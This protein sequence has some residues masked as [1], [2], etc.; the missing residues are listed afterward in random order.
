MSKHRLRIGAVVG[1]GLALALVVPTAAQ[2]AAPY[3]S[4][5]PPATFLNPSLAGYNTFWTASTVNFTT[6]GA[7]TSHNFAGTVNAPTATLERDDLL[8]SWIN[9]NATSGQQ[10]KAI[11]DSEYNNAANTYYDQSV[12][13][14]TGLGSVLGPIYVNGYQTGA[15]P[16]TRA[17]VNSSNG[18]TGSYVGTGGAT[19]PKNTYAHPRP[20]L[21]TTPGSITTSSSTAIAPSAACSDTEINGAAQKAIRAG[22][23][24]TDGANGNLKIGAVAARTDSTHQFSSIDV[25]LDAQ[26]DQIGICSGGSYPSGH[27]T[28]AYQAGITL[29][30]LLPELAPQILARASEGG[31]N[32]IVLG[33]HYPLDIMGGRIDGEAALAARWSDQKFRDEVL[34]PARNELIAYL[35]A[36]CGNTLAN[37]IANETPYQDDPYGGAAMPGGTSQIVTDRASALAVYKE[38]LNYGFAKVGPSNAAPSVP[39]G[40]SNLL[41]TAFPTLTD[42]QRTSVLAQTEISSGDP[43]DLTAAGGAAWERLDLASAMSATVQLNADGTAT[44]VSTGGA[45]TVLP[46]AATAAAPTLA[47]TGV[48]NVPWLLGGAALLLVAGA[49]FL[50]VRRRPRRH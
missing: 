7:T 43:L 39:A 27:T 5:N 36:Q 35:E 42:D 19:G 21:P 18:L 8:T 15:L 13:A 48:A 40:A 28:T 11:Q 46:A 17:L 29:A 32:R 2:A 34:T 23:S 6:A 26:Y 49:V 20:F 10:F 47:A 37:C 22:K 50:V 12:T 14:S 9:Q 24:Y 45:P 4:D 30:T 1:A 16:L 44:V 33:V 38:R 3:P 25:P 41:L 31:N